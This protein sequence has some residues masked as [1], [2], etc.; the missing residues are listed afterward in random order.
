MGLL[1]LVAKEFL[2]K[3]ARQR[4]LKQY[5]RKR[6]KSLS[7]SLT[8][9]HTHTNACAHTRVSARTHALSMSLLRSLSLLA[10][11]FLGCRRMS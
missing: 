11:G 3:I 9:T 10:V 7:L 1:H 4:C 6:A 5:I 8:R 2:L